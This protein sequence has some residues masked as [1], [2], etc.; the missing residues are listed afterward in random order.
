[1]QQPINENNPV[2]FSTERENQYF[3]RKSARLNPKETARHICAFANASGGKLVIG[4]EDNGE[5]TG[6]RRDGAR[7]I[8][9]FEQGRS[10][11]ASQCPRS[12]PCASR[13]ST[14]TARTIAS[15]CLR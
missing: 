4:I 5:I 8:E 11:G 1:M 13:S 15:S 6:F 9:E 2:L 7:N 3:D 12:I 14:R 10:W